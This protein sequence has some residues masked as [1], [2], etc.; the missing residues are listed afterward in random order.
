MLVSFPVLPSS[1]LITVAAPS[2]LRQLLFESRQLLQVWLLSL[3]F[4]CGPWWILCPRKKETFAIIGL[5]FDLCTV[6][7]LV[8]IR[9]TPSNSILSTSRWEM[10]ISFVRKRLR[11]SSVSLGDSSWLSFMPKN[12]ILLRRVKHSRFI[13]RLSSW[14]KE[15]S[16]F[17]A[18]FNSADI[19]L[20]VPCSSFTLLWVTVSFL[21][22]ARFSLSVVRIPVATRV[23]CPTFLLFVVTCCRTVQWAAMMIAVFCNDVC[24]D[25][26]RR[27]LSKGRFR[28]YIVCLRLSHA[29]SKARAAR[30]MQKIAHNSRHSTLPI[31][32]IVVGS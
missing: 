9:W 31:P 5:G 17:F 4:W 25:L 12:L 16:F 26:F 18:S 23:L 22:V 2:S 30:V 6:F 14:P 7:G 3:G 21:L 15:A 10:F 27:L 13:W 20:A 19:D 29:I 28:R 11:V 24:L 8:G 1:R 32:T